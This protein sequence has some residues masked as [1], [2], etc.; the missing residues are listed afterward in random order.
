MKLIR[1]VLGKVILLSDAL[2]SPRG[3]TRDS[4][5]Q[6]RIDEKAS[7]YALYQFEACPFCVKVRRALK[8]QSVD[9]ELRDAKNNVQFR[10]ELETQGGKIKVPCLRIE[11]NGHVEWLYESNDI[12]A[13]IQREFV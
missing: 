6:K 3:I 4:E 7:H 5:H 1:S 11:Q 13:F 8:R 9:I 10:Q 2:F 12:V